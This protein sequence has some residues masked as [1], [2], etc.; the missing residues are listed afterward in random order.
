V[1]EAPEGVRRAL[2]L[3]GRVGDFAGLEKRMA[4]LAEKV[5][6]QF[7]ALIDKPAAEARARR[8][9]QDEKNEEKL[10]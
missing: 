1:R 8:P 4:A 2:A 6:A 3:A 5:M 7:E 10:T 9:A